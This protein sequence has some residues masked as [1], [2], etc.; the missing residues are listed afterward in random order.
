MSSDLSLSRATSYLRK[1]VLWIMV[2]NDITERIIGCGINVH[3]ALGTGLLESAYE[4]CLYYELL[5]SGLFVE[6]QKAIPLI[7]KAVKMDCGYR[8]DLVVER[9]IIV[10][11]KAVEVLNEIHIMQTVTHLKLTNCRLGLLM[12][13]NVIRLKDGIRRIINRAQGN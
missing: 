12:N 4:S 8:A 9:K 13:F 6:R 10:E 3:M 1:Q 11:V 5:E 2:E 7:Y